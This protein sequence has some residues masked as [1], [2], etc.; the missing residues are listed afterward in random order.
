[1]SRE[2]V[3]TIGFMR[4]CSRRARYYMFRYEALNQGV[5]VTGIDYMDTGPRSTLIK[6][7]SMQKSFKSHRCAME[8]DS[9]FVVWTPELP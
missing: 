1:M 5:E 9:R 8:F 7:E 6:L 4:K 3:L 2:N